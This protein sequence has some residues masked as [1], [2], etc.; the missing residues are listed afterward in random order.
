[1]E[2]CRDA[3]PAE[4]A[5]PARPLARSRARLRQ[6]A[7][8]GAAI[9]PK[10]LIP[11]FVKT[12]IKRQT[13]HM[14][15]HSQ[16]GQDLWVL[17]VFDQ[18]KGGYFVDVGAYDGVQLSNTYWLE[19]RFGWTGILIEANPRIFRMLERN[20]TSRCVLACIDGDPGTVHF[21]RAGVLGRI[22]PD[23]DDPDASPDPSVIELTSTTLMDVLAAHDAP[24]V[25]EYLSMDIEGGEERALRDF[26]FD[27]YTFRCMTVE[28]PSPLLQK[29][30]D[31]NG[32][33]CVK[34]FP[35]LDSFYVHETHLPR[36]QRNCVSFYRRRHIDI[37]HGRRDWPAPSGR[38]PAR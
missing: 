14:P 19:R 25:M 2:A 34:R 9:H 24:R 28:R 30:L 3:P 15:Q 5:P 21:K 13:R 8:E 31:E 26:D 17:E 20:R 7:K 29:L 27:R 16:V 35:A 33:T 38:P 32:Y 4:G 10:V 1:V 11:G 6:L 22:V 36:Y 23:G 18:L 37:S 12:W